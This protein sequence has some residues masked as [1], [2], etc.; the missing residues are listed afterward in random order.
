MQSTGIE[1]LAF[2]GS[3]LRNAWFL[4]AFCSFC[5]LNMS[6]CLSQGYL[7]LSK[8]QPEYLIT[9][10]SQ[11][12]TGGLSIYVSFPDWFSRTAG[13]CPIR[14]RVVPTKGLVF[15]SDGV[16][17][18]NIGTG[19]RVSQEGPCSVIEVEIKQGASEARSELLA[20]LFE[21][22]MITFYA[23][24]NGRKLNGQKSY[25]FNRGNSDVSQFGHSMAIISQAT[26]KNDTKRRAALAE[27]TKTGNWFTQEEYFSSTSRKGIYADASRLPSNWLAMSG[28]AQISI[29]M[30][31]FAQLAP[32][33]LDALKQY[34]LAGGIL[35]VGKVA[36]IAEITK[37]IP[38]D[39][40]RQWDGLGANKA[41]NTTES[42]SLPAQIS[43]LESSIDLLED[44]VWDR[45]MAI[46][47]RIAFLNRSGVGY[48]GAYGYGPYTLGNE[49]APTN[50][51]RAPSDLLGWSEKLGN[52]LAEVGLAY[53]DFQM[54]NME[55]LMSRFYGAEEVLIPNLK[56]E[57]NLTQPILVMHGFGIVRLDPRNVRESTNLLSEQLKDSLYNPVNRTERFKNGIGDDF[58]NWLIPAVG[59][60]PVIPFLTFVVLFVGIVVPGLMIWCNHHKRRVWLVVAMPLTA[61]AFTLLLFCYGIL[62]DGLGAISR[63]RSLA[64]VDTNGDG[65]VW[66]RQNYFAARVPEQGIVLSNDT[67]L[68]PMQVHSNNELRGCQQFD[69][70][71]KQQY[72]GLIP[73]RLQTQFS[74]T[75]PLRNLSVMTRGSKQDPTLN[76]NSIV[77][78]SD[79][80]WTIALFINRDGKAFIA[81]DVLDGQTAV[82]TE[83]PI[84][85]S[86]LLMRNTYQATPLSAPLDA[87]SADQ[88]S[89]T[90]TIS[91]F[92]SFGG[93][94]YRPNNMGIISE[95]KVWAQYVGLSSTNVFSNN[96]SK[97]CEMLPGTFIL[98][99]EQAPYLERCI[100]NVK[101][102][103]GLHTVIGQW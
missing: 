26:S 82:L 20:N 12:D 63:T 79:C 60:T 47:K 58:W 43:D 66:S 52:D 62:K 32:E 93:R 85:D 35:S 13:Y 74:V 11:G 21:T 44:T 5:F 89:L 96:A 24:L 83:M 53:I 81:K 38:I 23:T 46:E 99:T 42:A 16:L 65:V 72:L 14:V 78:A 86:M 40:R 97:R 94:N 41:K 75:H 45:F 30:D 101:D 36:T 100:P 15:K 18:L 95:E 103:D 28:L 33:Q 98:F 67:Q 64:F 73:P 91:G 51:E 34:V 19:N 80:K 37:Y 71:G 77:N 76:E 9:N 59:R 70:D 39:V 27:M 22:Q 92:F 4:A 88:V 50:R 61:A 1:R 90:Q 7:D 48:G 84:E 102:E 6:P 17:R 2:N 3:R 57:D 25:C 31:D 49:P 29:H 10:S 87:P 8:V 54:S 55:T 56:A 69:L 68:A